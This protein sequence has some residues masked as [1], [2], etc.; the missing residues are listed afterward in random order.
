MYELEPHHLALLVK[1]LEASDRADEARDEIGAGSLAVQSRLGEL[2]PHP[3]L[4]VERDSRAAFGTLMKQLGL[5]IEGPPPPSSR[6][7]RR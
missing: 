3:L 4:A 5:D 1:A 6:K 7:P 2:K